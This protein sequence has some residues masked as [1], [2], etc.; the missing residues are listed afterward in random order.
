MAR[1][2]E[3]EGAVIAADGASGLSGLIVRVRLDGRSRSL[4]SATT[5]EDG[6]FKF[7]LDKSKFPGRFRSHRIR[8]DV[9]AGRKKI[10]VIDGISN[11]SPPD[12][13][14][15][16][17]T[18]RVEA[19]SPRAPVEDSKVELSLSNTQ[20]QARIRLDGNRASASFGGNGADGSL[21]IFPSAASDHTD[22]EQAT[23]QL[24]GASG[25][26]LLANADCA[27]DFDVAGGER[28]SIAPGHVMVLDNEAN[29][30]LCRDCYDK[31]VV[32]VI[33]GA[34][35]YRPGIV[36]DRRAMT[37]DRLPLAL[38]GKVACRVD[39]DFGVIAVGDLLTTS[40]TPGHA[41]KAHDRDL[42]FGAVIGKALRPMVSG[43]GLIPILVALQ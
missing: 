37:S 11:W 1:T 7:T 10:R 36:L 26:I 18:L 6:R 43:T 9:F 38:V 14:P 2:F 30:A 32:G 13:V 33:S 31:R 42:A 20:G 23:I 16:Q 19:E 34:G 17:I 5:D 35:G 29:L 28:P 12:N 4:A 40:T 27:E 22:P 21:F 8:V 41:M 39:A 24:D 15:G 25:D 3:I